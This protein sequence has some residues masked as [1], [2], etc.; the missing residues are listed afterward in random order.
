MP[1]KSKQMIKAEQNAIARLL[2]E[3][4]RD[5]DIIE[6]LKIPESTF[7]M[8]KK[9]IQDFIGQNWEK[10]WAES[11]KYQ[12]VKLIDTFEECYTFNRDIMYSEEKETKDRIEASKTMCEAR[13]NI[14]NIVNKG[15]TIKPT[16]KPEEMILKP[17]PPIVLKQDD[18]TE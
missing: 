10:I 14:F 18:T 11:G 4:Y 13:V 16:R 9:A 17:I 6:N 12:A 1:R 7:Y 3:G 8:H 2:E 5:M 15:P